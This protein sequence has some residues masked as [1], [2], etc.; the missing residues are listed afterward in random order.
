MCRLDASLLLFVSCSPC[1]I[2][3]SSFRFRHVFVLFLAL[4]LVFLAS[5]GEATAQ[6]DAL[7]GELMEAEAEVED[8]EASGVSSQLSSTVRSAA[9]YSRSATSSLFPSRRG[10][11]PHSYYEDYA[12]FSPTGTAAASAAASWQQPQHLM[13]AGISIDSSPARR[14]TIVR[15]PAR[16]PSGAAPAAGRAG[17]G[18]K[19]QAYTPSYLGYVPQGIELPLPNS[20]KESSL[21]FL[22]ENQQRQQQL[23]QPP[24]KKQRRAAARQA[25]AAAVR[26][27]SAV[28]ASSFHFHSG[29][30]PVPQ[31][32]ELAPLQMPVGGYQAVEAPTRF[33]PMQQQEQLPYG[34]ISPGFPAAHVGPL[35]HQQAAVSAPG[36]AIGVDGGHEKKTKRDKKAKAPKTKKRQRDGSPQYQPLPEPQL[37]PQLQPLPQHLPPA[38]PPSMGEAAPQR[39]PGMKPLRIRLSFGTQQQQQQQQP[40]PAP[41]Q[42]LPF[43]QTQPLY[44]Y[45]EPHDLQQQQP[46]PVHGQPTY[47][48]IQHPAFDHHQQLPQQ[49]QQQPVAAAPPKFRIRLPTQP[50][51]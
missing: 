33:S 46:Q 30:A 45:N 32:Q 50:P 3:S 35:L 26:A 20:N 44:G 51:Q 18:G 17:G 34:S 1:R 27:A 42:P 19:K 41:A 25:E 24:T 10:A 37:M 39:P 31:T 16:S 40:S 7:G 49:Q 23:V 29:A 12:A 9:S 11:G 13:Q 36:A 43:Q 5:D 47:S 6:G 15:L 14:R 2:R 48:P 4:H 28:A 21:S 22:K 8:D 38:T